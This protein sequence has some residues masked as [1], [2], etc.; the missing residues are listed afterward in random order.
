M[1]GPFHVVLRDAI[2]QRGLPL[3]RLRARLAERGIR[4][5]IAS[6]SDWQHGRAWP[7]QANSLRAIGALEEILGLPDRTLTDLLAG[8]PTTP[9]LPRQGVDESTGP[10]S[11]LLDQL[12]GSR[13]WDL[14]TLTT[15]HI[16][17]VDEHRCPSLVTVRSLV[18]ARKD[19][20]DRLVVRYFAAA[21]GD[22]DR[23]TV[24]PTRNCRTG[25]ILRHHTGRVM[26]AEL[27][28]GQPLRA[29]DTWIFEVELA[30]PTAQAR[31][32]F[33]HGF[34][35]MEGNYLLEVRFHPTALPSQVNGYL[36]ADLYT[37]SHR[38]TDL[39][40]TNHNA[41]HLT[42]ADMTAGVLGIQ[43]EWP[44]RAGSA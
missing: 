25:R 23:V 8:R 26:V 38:L 17:T 44:L 41:V 3:Q 7:Q 42:A 14:D 16:V 4:V 33:A 1:S 9:F 6:L 32:D 34:R 35:R 37:E 21:T 31:S 22:V 2:R 36:R 30:D 11:E 10:I 24:R 15:E 27:V 43:W 28:F 13:A 19:G 18:R 39:R 5:G 29:G 12:P 40:L 20:V